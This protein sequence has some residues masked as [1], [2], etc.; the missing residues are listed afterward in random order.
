MTLTRLTGQL[1]ARGGTQAAQ[2]YIVV[3]ITVAAVIIVGIIGVIEGAV[4][5]RYQCWLLVLAILLF[6]LGFV[7]IIG[8]G[9]RHPVQVFPQVSAATEARARPVSQVVATLGP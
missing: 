8:L 5:H 2:H 9:W 7:V 3:V 4:A 1:A 6:L